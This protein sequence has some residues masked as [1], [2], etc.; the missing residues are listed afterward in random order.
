VRRGKKGVDTVKK[1]IGKV[2]ALFGL[3]VSIYTLA[4]K[5]AALFGVDLDKLLGKE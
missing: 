4:P 3:I 2:M 5:V 1:V